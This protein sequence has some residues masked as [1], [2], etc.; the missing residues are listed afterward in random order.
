M[1]AHLD[2]TERT[3]AAAAAAQVVLAGTQGTHLDSRDARRTPPPPHAATLDFDA[4]AEHTE[5]DRRPEA[6]T[7]RVIT[8]PVQVAIGKPKRHNHDVTRAEAPGK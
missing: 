2:H 1:P 6:M 5:A 7:I 4:V 8:P 3:D